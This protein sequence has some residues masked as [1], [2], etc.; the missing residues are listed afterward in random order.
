MFII[1]SLSLVR[2]FRIAKKDAD[3]GVFFAI[4]IA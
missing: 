4:F 2:T 3:F 1:T